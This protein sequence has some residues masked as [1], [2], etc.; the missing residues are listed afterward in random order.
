MK[1][2]LEHLNHIEVMT[3]KRKMDEK[4]KNLKENTMSYEEFDWME[5]L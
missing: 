2:Y 3:E 1:K 4:N 5:M